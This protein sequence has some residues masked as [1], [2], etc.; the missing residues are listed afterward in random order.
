MGDRASWLLLWVLLSACGQAAPDDVSDAGGAGQRE[1]AS[2]ADADGLCD[3]TEAQLG[4]D[5]DRADSD[6]DGVPDVFEYLLRSDPGDPGA[7][8]SEQLLALPAERDATLR[9]E[10]RVTVDG[11]GEGHAGVFEPVSSVY[12]D[13]TAAD[14]FAGTTAL[15]AQPPDHVRGVQAGSGRFD[16]VIGE[17]RLSF[18]LA[19]SYDLGE[20]PH[21]DCVRAYP[22]RFS[23]K[24]DG[25]A[26]SQS[27]RLLLQTIPDGLSPRLDPYCLPTRCL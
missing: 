10:L 11:A 23:V 16:T 17:T 25:S 26:S 22:L 1:T 20:P 8:A 18:A 27:Q 21:D 5:P 15:S 2:D 3:A 12:P 19:F 9:A 6:A 4:T 7:P 14:F 24:P 13:L